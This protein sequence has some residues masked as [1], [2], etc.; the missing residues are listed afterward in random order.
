[1]R[2]TTK[3]HNRAF[4]VAY[5]ADVQRVYYTATLTAFCHH[6]ALAI[7]GLLIPSALTALQFLA[8]LHRS[9]R[10]GYI[11]CAVAYSLLAPQ[12]AQATGRKCSVRTLERGLAA[13]RALGLISMSWWT[14][15]DQRMR[16]GDHE[17]VA[18]GT[19][20][21]QTR[22]G[23][24]CLQIRIIT[25]TER[26]VAL[27]DR[28]TCRQGGVYMR[29]YAHLLTPAKMADSPN[30]DLVD[31]PTKIN[32]ESTDVHSEEDVCD[33]VSDFEPSSPQDELVSSSP[34]EEGRP[35]P[36][37][38]PAPASPP[39]GPPTVEHQTIEPPPSNQSETITPE[40][41][42]EAFE[43]AVA[44]VQNLGIVEVSPDCGGRDRSRHTSCASTV[45][46]P[47][48]QGVTRQR[49]RLPRNGANKTSWPVAR[50]FLLAELHDALSNFSQRQADTIYARARFELSRNYPAGWPTAVD[51]AYWVGRFARFSPHQRTH[52][53]IRDILP[54]LKNPAAVVPTEPRK[55]G[56]GKNAPKKLGQVLDP[57]LQKLMD[58]FGKD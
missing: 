22:D 28:S 2:H 4:K 32:Q 8:A 44:F 45:V 26:A 52:H 40:K 30:N 5:W 19:A 53:M 34:V 35:T 13:L 39:Q 49:P 6:W 56:E 24:K 17:V 43:K 25:L 15:P 23:W 11:G 54:L 36:P 14:M 51:W 58:R 57:F 9:G 10:G 29:H 46:N 47:P 50:L 38:C 20:R 33:L 12:I 18:R 21:V 37:P 55:Y 16:N 7:L 3:R 48:P 27:W 31:K 41:N 42:P 1:M